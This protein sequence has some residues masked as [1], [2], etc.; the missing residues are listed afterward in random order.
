MEET[1]G[2]GGRKTLS[3]PFFDRI[4]AIL[5]QGGRAEELREDLKQSAESR[6]AEKAR[7]FANGDAPST[8]GV[9][10]DIGSGEEDRLDDEKQSPPA[11]AG[12]SGEGKLDAPGGLRRLGVDWNEPFSLADGNVP[13][14]RTTLLCA[15]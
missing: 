3:S 15:E 6:L 11:A 1:T 14:L 5:P 9:V 4:S 12:R 2:N 7:G 8:R 13:I 10:T